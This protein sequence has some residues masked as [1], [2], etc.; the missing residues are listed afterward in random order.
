MCHLTFLSVGS[1][2][3]EARNNPLEKETGALHGL[4]PGMFVFSL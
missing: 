2:C 4:K 1:R 3:A